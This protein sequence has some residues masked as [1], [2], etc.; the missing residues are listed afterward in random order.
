MIRKAKGP[1]SIALLSAIAI[2]LMNTAPTR[3]SDVVEAPAI[4]FSREFVHLTLADALDASLTNAEWRAYENDLPKI[5]PASQ[6][7]N[8]E[9]HKL[10][11]QNGSVTSRDLQMLWLTHGSSLSNDAFSAVLKLYS[12]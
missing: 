3:A 4:D 2:A 9:L 6:Q 1:F 10:Y 5:I 11:G 8:V 7:V 12:Y